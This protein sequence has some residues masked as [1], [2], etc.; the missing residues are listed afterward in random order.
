LVCKSRYALQ[1]QIKNT[2]AASFSYEQTVNVEQSSRCRSD[3][4][5]FA[6][7]LNT[8]DY[9]VPQSGN[10]PDIPYEPVIQQ[11]LPGCP[12]LCSIYSESYPSQIPPYVLEFDVETGNIVFNYNDPAI[13]GTSDNF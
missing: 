10:G 1:P 13:I 11:S 4:I 7:V 8:I 9:P 5:D 2:F 3:F 12:I 6:T